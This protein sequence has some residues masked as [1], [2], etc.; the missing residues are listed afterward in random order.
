MKDSDLDSVLELY[1]GMGVGS[2][3]L[4]LRWGDCVAPKDV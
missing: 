2:K 1:E 3:I 4:L